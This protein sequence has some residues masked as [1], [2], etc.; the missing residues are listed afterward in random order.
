M[1]LEMADDGLVYCRSDQ[2]AKTLKAELQAR[3]AE[4]QN[5]ASK[6]SARMLTHDHVPERNCCLGVSVAKA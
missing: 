1:H 6:L 2:E 5:D 4:C 3:L